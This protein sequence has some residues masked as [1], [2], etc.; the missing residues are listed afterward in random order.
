VSRFE[1]E[2][3]LKQIVRP[4]H[5]ALYDP[6][7]VQALIEF[8]NNDLR[9]NPGS[10]QVFNHERDEPVNF[11]VQHDTTLWFTLWDGWVL[12]GREIFLPRFAQPDEVLHSLQSSEYPTAFPV[13]RRPD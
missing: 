11:P 5:M 3:A 6:L 12:L 9:I 13:P 10:T 4:I 1:F 7:I 8:L 2:V